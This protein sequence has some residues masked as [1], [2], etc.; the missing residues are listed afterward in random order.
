MNWSIVF[1][2][3]SPT[4]RLFSRFTSCVVNRSA[5]DIDSISLRLETLP[6]TVSLQESMTFWFVALKL[7]VT[8]M[9][10][11]PFPMLLKLNNV[12]LK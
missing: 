2:Q 8:N 6:I 4:S 7:C 5:F 12:F 9:L 10:E 1:M 3:N 11:N